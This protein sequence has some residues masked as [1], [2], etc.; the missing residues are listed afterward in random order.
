MEKKAKAEAKLA[1]RNQ[2]KLEGGV[3]QREEAQGSDM[4]SPETNC[5]D[6]QPDPQDSSPDHTAVS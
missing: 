4:E 6:D 3:N 5:S 1:R 2:R